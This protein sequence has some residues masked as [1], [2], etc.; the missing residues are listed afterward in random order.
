MDAMGKS[1]AAHEKSIL[2][3][4]A[5]GMC[6]QY[7]YQHFLK[8]KGYLVYTTSRRPVE[9]ARHICHDLNDPLGFEKF[10]KKV[11]LIVHCAAL[12]D[13][14]TA[15]Y[16]V[17]DANVRSMFNVVNYALSA[18]ASCLIHFSS[19]SVYGK[20]AMDTCVE[21]SHSPQ[22]VTSYGLSKVLS[23]ALCNSMLRDTLR[24]FH[25]RLGYV[26]SPNAPSRYL[27]RRFAE[28]LVRGDS[29]ELANPDVT[30]FFLFDR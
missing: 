21:E 9:Y 24:W 2:V 30:R 18:R 5:S 3:T 23:E 20:P 17:V 10:P 16:S 1:E 6:G 26:L 22:P 13:E 8:G 14:T 15:E 28:K 7:I 25:L 11:D 29:I 27:V 12:V 4:G 19:I